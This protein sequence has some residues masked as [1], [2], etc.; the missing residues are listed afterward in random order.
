MEETIISDVVKAIITPDKSVRRI[1][2]ELN[3]RRVPNPFQ[4]DTRRMWSFREVGRA[5][6]ILGI[7]LAGRKLK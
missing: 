7:L 6:T 2:R 4:A 1:K 3:R 5:A